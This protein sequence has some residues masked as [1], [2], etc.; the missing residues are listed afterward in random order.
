[1]LRLTTSPVATAGPDG[2]RCPAEP[3]V[4]RVVVVA[5]AEAAVARDSAPAAT[6]MALVRLN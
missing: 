1:V 6:R 3:E 4:H 2:L 5:V